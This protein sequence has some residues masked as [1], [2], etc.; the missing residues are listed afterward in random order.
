VL[1]GAGDRVEEEMTKIGQRLRI[2]LRVLARH[3]PRWVN[4]Q[5]KKILLKK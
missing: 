3:R 2:L 1:D 5:N 4:L